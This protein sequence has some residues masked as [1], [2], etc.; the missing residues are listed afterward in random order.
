MEA[1]DPMTRR[2][3]PLPPHAARLLAV[4]REEAR[5]LR[6]AGYD[7]CLSDGN[8]AVAAHALIRRGLAVPTNNA[9]TTLALTPAGLIAKAAQRGQ[10]AE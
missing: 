8:A 1:S 7:A 5:S 4:L 6:R 2:T 9:A 10:G 3:P